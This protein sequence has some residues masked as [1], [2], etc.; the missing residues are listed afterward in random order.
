VRGDP[1]AASVIT[2]PL[3]I[4]IPRN[5]E[6]TNERPR[7]VEVTVRGTASSP[8]FGQPSPSC[9]IDLQSAEEGQH[10]APLTPDNVRITDANE[11]VW[12]L[13]RLLDAS[14]QPAQSRAAPPHCGEA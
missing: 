6:I 2:V 11:F 1:G 8:W 7:S 4:R 5:V 13:E 3:E 14:W 10:V 9:V 12:P